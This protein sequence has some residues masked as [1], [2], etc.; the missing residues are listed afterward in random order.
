MSDPI[1]LFEAPPGP[2]SQALERA[3]IFGESAK[4]VG[5]LCEPEP[6]LRTPGTPA[7]LFLN[8]GIIHRVG[9]SRIHVQ[10]ARLLAENGFSSLRF[11]FSGIGDSES[12]RDSLRFEESAVRETRE[13]MDYLERTTGIGS[14][15]LVGL[16]S[17]ADMGF[18][19]SQADPRV[20]GLAQ[21]DPYAYRTWGW[22]LRYYGP[23]ATRLSTWTNAVR[24]RVRGL[25][26]RIR[27]S[28]ASATASDFVA[29]EY[30]RVFPPKREVESGV[31]RL[32]QRGVRLFV[33]FTGGERLFNYAEQY[34]EAFSRVP[35][36]NLLR[37]HHMPR[38]DHTFTDPHSQRE[39]LEYLSGWMREFR[40]VVG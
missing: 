38:A 1:A 3:L 8:S 15:V 6:A 26:E 21:F 27:P 40:R 32:V 28:Q 29:P 39:L 34:R 30:R 37:V 16:C 33:V 14:F 4:L 18:E 7:V 22:F 11:D 5:V 19:V 10:M 36:G 17:G 13:A 35:F 9:A 31:G 24:V 12:R 20:V 25:R 23:R 2:G